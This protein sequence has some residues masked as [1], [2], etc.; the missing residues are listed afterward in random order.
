[1]HPTLIIQELQIIKCIK[2]YTSII[3]KLIKFVKLFIWWLPQTSDT[4]IWVSWWFE[5]MYTLQR[6]TW[7]TCH[8]HLTLSPCMVPDHTYLTRST[9]SNISRSHQKICTYP[10]PP[11]RR[12][13][14]II[15][16]ST[17]VW[18]AGLYQLLY[19]NSQWGSGEKTTFCWQPVTRLSGPISPAW[20]RY[21]QYWLAGTNPSILNRHRR[22]L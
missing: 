5:L 6:K 13:P 11:R 12:A 7:P 1:V 22:R 17:A 18:S 15:H 20:D 3:D 10:L 16:S 8:T 19:H 4:H 21:V 9:H 14:N 2:Q